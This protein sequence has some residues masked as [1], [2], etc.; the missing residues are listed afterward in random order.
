MN[1]IEN[2]YAIGIVFSFF[3]VVLVILPRA[4]EPGS[5]WNLDNKTMKTESE[6]LIGLTYVLLFLIIVIASW[7]TVIPYMIWVIK[8]HFE[9][10]NSKLNVALPEEYNK[11]IVLL[12]LK[13]NPEGVAE[14]LS[15]ALFMEELKLLEIVTLSTG[16]KDALFALPKLEGR[17]LNPEN[18]PTNFRYLKDIMEDKKEVANY[19]KRIK[20]YLNQ[21]Y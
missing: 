3:V 15:E 18:L 10:N 12:D 7:L 6:T 9:S 17:D 4:I 14:F 13:G 19:P 16:R 1:I 20:S 5:F 21:E 2:F 8:S 11:I